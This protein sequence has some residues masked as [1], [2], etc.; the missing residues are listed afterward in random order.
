MGPERSAFLHLPVAPL[1]RIPHS[2][3]PP[4]HTQ[5]STST[6]ASRHNH[7]VGASIHPLTVPAFTHQRRF[8]TTVEHAGMVGEVSAFA[9]PLSSGARLAARALLVERRSLRW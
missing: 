5:R 8:V 3:R 1:H 2:T 9:E 4:P 6:S 7:G